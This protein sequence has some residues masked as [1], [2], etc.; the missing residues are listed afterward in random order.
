M[1]VHK[2]LAQQPVQDRTKMKWEER[3]VFRYIFSVSC[4]CFFSSLFVKLKTT[5]STMKRWNQNVLWHLSRKTNKGDSGSMKSYEKTL[6]E[7]RRNCF[8]LI[9]KTSLER[10]L[11]AIQQ[12]K[13]LTFYAFHENFYSYFVCPYLI[14]WLVFVMISYR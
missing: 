8:F 13:V 11:L 1:N 3:K 12:E 7:L 5:R 4:F 10:F 6:N 9:K 2:F 14:P